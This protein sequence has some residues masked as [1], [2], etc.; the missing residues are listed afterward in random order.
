[1][2][3]ANDPLV[4][5]TVVEEIAMGLVDLLEVIVEPATNHLVIERLAVSWLL[6]YTKLDQTRL[7]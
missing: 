6:S 4:V 7:G 5:Q 3:A 2:V 1:M